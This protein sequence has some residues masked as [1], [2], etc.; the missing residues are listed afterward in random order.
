MCLDAL[1]V[2]LRQFTDER[3][4]GQFHR[5]K[6]LAMA[7]AGEAG[8]L[9]AELRWYTDSEVETKVL[10]V[11][12]ER[13]KLEHEVADVLL[14]LVRLADV[15]DIDLLAAARRKIAINAKRYPPEKVYGSSHKYTD[16]HETDTTEATE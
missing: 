4:W 1:A 15:C 8:E 5:P 3:N 13:E 12:A 14:F 11:P 9:V 7:V 10:G 6:N 16:L 2:E